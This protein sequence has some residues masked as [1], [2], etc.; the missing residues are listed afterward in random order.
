MPSVV[1]VVLTGNYAG[2]ETDICTTA[3]AAAAR[4]RDVAVIGGDRN[5]CTT[6]P[7]QGRLGHGGA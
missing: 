4:R 3:C 2:V 5:G 6:D 7:I 1:D